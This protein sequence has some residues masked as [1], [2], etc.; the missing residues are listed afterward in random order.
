MLWLGSLV[1]RIVQL[2]QSLL[3]RVVVDVIAPFHQ[4][5]GPDCP[6]RGLVKTPL[7][8]SGNTSESCD[9]NFSSLRL[10]THAAGLDDTGFRFCSS[11][12]RTLSRSSCSIASSSS[13]QSCNIFSGSRS[14]CMRRA[15]SFQRG[16]SVSTLIPPLHRREK[17]LT[18]IT[19]GR[20]RDGPG[21]PSR[22]YRASD[23]TAWDMR[24]N[25]DR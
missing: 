24:P 21:E 16:S 8:E 5:P 15:I 19:F 4:G 7:H 25:L 13:R 23:C 17:Y 20:K 1:G 9:A 14:V 6:F 11:L 22:F 12:V 2:H 18:H 10:E 3:R